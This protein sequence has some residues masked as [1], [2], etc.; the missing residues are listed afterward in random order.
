VE[1]A[2][3]FCLKEAAVSDIMVG[4]KKPITSVL[5]GCLGLVGI[6]ALA[7]GCSSSQKAP[8]LPSSSGQ[9]AYAIHY[10]DE[11]QAATKA[12]SEAQARNKQLSSGFAAHV[13]ELKKPDWSKVE[14]IIDDSDQAGKSADFAEAE[15]DATAVRSFW[16]AEKN[17]LTARVNGNAQHALKQAGCTADTGGAIGFALG[18]AINKQLQKKLRSKNEAF[19]VIERYKTSLGPQNTSSLEK[20]ADEVSEAS[21]DVNMLM[22]VQHNRVKRLADDKDDVKKTL[23]RFIKEET[24]FQG[25]PGRNELEKRASQERVTA[26]QKSKSE[27][28]AVGKQADQIAKDSDKTID[29]SK[30][31]YED[32]LKAIKTKVEEKKKS[33]PSK[34]EKGS[35]QP[36]PAPSTALPP[37]HESKPVEKPAE[38]PAEKPPESSQAPN[39]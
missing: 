3:F 30:K 6:G 15:T 32:A 35:A 37:K 36:A 12:I 17:E 39:P 8:V 23:D 38:K 18:D 19:V 26:A 20:L 2:C 22:V 11:L 34:G 14:V 13:E 4:M 16:D 1:S 24:E 29:A 10:N 28:D 21:Y 31:E 27:I 33:E 5:L 9:S 7:S 25:E